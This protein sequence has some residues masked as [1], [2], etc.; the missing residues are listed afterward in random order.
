MALDHP[1]P[2]SSASQIFPEHVKEENPYRNVKQVAHLKMLDG[3]KPVRDKDEKITETT[4]VQKGERQMKPE[5]VQTDRRWYGSVMLASVRGRTFD[6]ISPRAQ[7][8]RPRIEVGLLH[9]LADAANEAGAEPEEG[10]SSA[11]IEVL[12]PQTH[13]DFPVAVHGSGSLVA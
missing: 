13:A 10:S 4:T 8:K 9:E 7:R 5:R 6:T 12:E 11:P 1:K 2:R 3:G